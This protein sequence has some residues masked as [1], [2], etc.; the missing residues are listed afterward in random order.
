MRIWIQLFADPDS[1][2]TLKSQ[3]VEFLHENILK[4]TKYGTGSYEVT[5]AFLKGRKP[6]LFVNFG[7]FP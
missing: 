4:V 7:Q 3:K 2:E 6:D 5:N 1:G